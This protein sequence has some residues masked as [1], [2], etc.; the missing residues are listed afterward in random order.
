V[1]ADADRQS[2]VATGAVFPRPALLK[3]FFFWRW[4]GLVEW[5]LQ[6]HIRRAR[7]H[8]RIPLHHRG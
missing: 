2:N 7:L 1:S 8:K 3:L 5:T 4:R 6:A